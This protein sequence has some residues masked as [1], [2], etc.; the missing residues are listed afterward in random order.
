MRWVEF[1]GFFLHYQNSITYLWIFVNSCNQSKVRMKLLS[2]QIY[3]FIFPRYTETW[4]SISNKK[5]FFLLCLPCT[6]TRP[7]THE[8]D[9]QKRQ[10]YLL[11]TTTH[12]ENNEQ[13]CNRWVC[14]KNGFWNFCPKIMMSCLGV[15]LSFFMHFRWPWLSRFFA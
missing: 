6:G 4:N 9:E 8:Y 1:T 15:I 13:A 3:S 7:F 10:W 14:T 5:S 2:E 11:L 12:R